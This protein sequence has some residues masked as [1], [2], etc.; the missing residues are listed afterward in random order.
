MYRSVCLLE[1]HGS[2]NGLIGQVILA[3]MIQSLLSTSAGTNSV[4]NYEWQNETGNINIMHFV[5]S[6]P[7]LKDVY[8]IHS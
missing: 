5:S 6:P 4:I 2:L 1:E 8:K 7:L 3:T